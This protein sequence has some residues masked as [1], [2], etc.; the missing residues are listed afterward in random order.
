MT[1]KKTAFTAHIGRARTHIQQ[2]ARIRLKPCLLSNTIFY[3]TSVL[4]P[5]NSKNSLQFVSVCS[6]L[7]YLHPISKFASNLWGQIWVTDFG[8]GQGVLAGQGGSRQ[9]ASSGYWPH[10]HCVPREGRVEKSLQAPVATMD[11]RS[12]TC[13][14]RSEALSSQCP[15][16]RKRS[17]A[18]RFS[19]KL[20]FQD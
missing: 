12:S 3:R 1:L 10:G 9:V 20:S 16:P 14:A 5:L 6:S 17:S 13:T 7:S 19:H 11:P 4:F 15:L 2:R 18:F 8:A